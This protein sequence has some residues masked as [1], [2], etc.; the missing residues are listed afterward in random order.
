MQVV[1]NGTSGFG[2]KGLSRKVK[3]EL[4]WSSVRE[5]YLVVVS[6]PGEVGHRY[7]F[8]AM[9]DSIQ[10]TVWDVFMFDPDFRIE[11]PKRYYRQGINNI[12][13]ND[14]AMVEHP[15]SSLNKPQDSEISVTRQQY[16]HPQRNGDRHNN[17]NHS[18]L[19][20]VKSRVSRVFHSKAERSHEGVSSSG[21]K[22]RGQREENVDDSDDSSSIPPRPWTP[23]LD[24]STN[25]NPL[26]VPEDLRSPIADD[27]AAGE[28]KTNEEVSK[29]TFYIVNSQMKLKLFARNEVCSS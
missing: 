17:D 13:Y 6:E 5:S 28:G 7:K 9:T 22:N 8:A 3:K 16:L 21:H 10:L 27:Q 15:I 14:P 20:S 25:P 1:K 19:G 23:M 26:S 11:Q 2:R 29:H 18:L 4:R 24:P 12:L